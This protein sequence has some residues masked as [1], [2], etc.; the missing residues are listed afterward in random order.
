M[1]DLAQAVRDNEHVP[2][3]GGEAAAVRVRKAEAA[4]VPELSR[5]LAAAFFDDP[6]LSWVY[7]DPAPRQEILP[8]V[9]R[10][11]IDACQAGDEV[12]T[13]D[14]HIAGAVCV[15]PGREPDEAQLADLEQ[16]S[17]DYAP[18]AFEL[19]E[20]MDAEHP[21]E[22]HYYLFF[23]GTR[24]EWQSRGIGSALLEQLLEP[25]DRD[26][27]PAYL[28]ATSERNKRLYLRHGFEVRNEVRLPGGAAFWPMWREPG[29][30]L[31]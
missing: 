9:F 15:P 31:V 19:S 30:I 5:L 8:A 17:G 10:T 27:V 7:P 18:R 2:T 1:S 24:P 25:C 3:R 11:F 26:G 20:L 21:H 14:R 16:I 6:V 13:T 12:Y 4:D 28:D 22:P 29:N 23:L